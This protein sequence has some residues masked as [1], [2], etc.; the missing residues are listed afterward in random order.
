V[1]TAEGLYITFIPQDVGFPVLAS[2]VMVALSTTYFTLIYY[3]TYY[4]TLKIEAT[5]SSET[6]LTFQRTTRRCIQED[7]TLYTTRIR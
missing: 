7:I 5:Y 4:S 2:V 3:L 6:P 1:L